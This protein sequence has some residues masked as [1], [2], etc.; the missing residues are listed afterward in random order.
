MSMFLGF[1][2]V[3]LETDLF[4]QP[5]RVRNVFPEPQRR[6]LSKYFTKSVT[7]PRALFF[8]WEK[9]TAFFQYIKNKMF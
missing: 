7:F 5:K 9:K 3:F 8:I 2:S 6:L 1:P 4:M